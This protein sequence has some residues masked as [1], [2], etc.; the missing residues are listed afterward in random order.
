MTYFSSLY[1]ASP[2]RNQK[3]FEDNQL[4]GF[5]KNTRIQEKKMAQRKTHTLYD[6]LAAV[7]AGKRRFEN[8]FQGVS[9]MILESDIEKVMVQGKTTYN[10][11]LFSPGGKHIIDMDLA[12]KFSNL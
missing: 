1:L 7:K 8:A 5:E 10:F 12:K 2:F 3:I 6:H 11:K 9:R 4:D